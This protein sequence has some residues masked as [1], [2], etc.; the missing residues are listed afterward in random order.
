[1]LVYA[2]HHSSYIKQIKIRFLS[3]YNINTPI[4]KWFKNTLTG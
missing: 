4:F 2:H 3:Y 1:M